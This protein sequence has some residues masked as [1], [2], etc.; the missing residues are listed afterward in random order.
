MNSA[1][2]TRAL[3]IMQPWAWLIVNGFKDVEN[4]DWRTHYRGP[5]LIHTG[6]KVDAGPMADLWAGAHPVTGERLPDHVRDAFRDAGKLPT[7]G[8]VGVASI[9]GCTDRSASPWFV[10][11]YGFTLASARPLPFV[12]TKGALGFFAAEYPEPAE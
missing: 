4:R 10:G 2:P 3:S 9:T 11:A 8:L 5:V 6:L 12:R 7:G 1:L